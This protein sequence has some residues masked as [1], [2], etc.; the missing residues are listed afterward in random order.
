LHFPDCL[1]RFLRRC[2]GHAAG[3]DD[4]DMRLVGRIAL[5]QAKAVKQLRN[6]LCIILI[7]FPLPESSVL[8]RMMR[9]GLNRKMT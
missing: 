2:R 7:G 1:S 3:V 8:I 5:P 6:L 9:P 4:N